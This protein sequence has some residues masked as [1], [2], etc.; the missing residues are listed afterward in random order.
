VAISILAVAVGLG[1]GYLDS[2]TTSDDAQVT[3]IALAVSSFVLSTASPRVAWFVGLAVGA[4]VVVFNHL[5]TGGYGSLIALAFSAGG[6][7]I[8]YGL[9]RALFGEG[10]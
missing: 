6:A 8:G 7:V 5:S 10:R 4:P 2:R 9:G 3:A 1:I